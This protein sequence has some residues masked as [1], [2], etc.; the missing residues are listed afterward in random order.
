MNE[1][2]GA[3]VAGAAPLWNIISVVLPLGAAALGVLLLAANP[4]GGGDFAGAMGSAVLF[5][6]GVGVACGL[7][8][9]AAIIALVRGERRAWLSVIG[10]V[11]NAAVVLPILALLA[12]D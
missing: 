4:R 8:A 9:V 5:V 2:T 3:S 6:F 10:L 7:G 11:G 12:R 1:T